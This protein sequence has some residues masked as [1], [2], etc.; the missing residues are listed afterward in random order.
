MKVTDLIAVLT[1]RAAEVEGW[2]FDVREYLDADGDGCIQLCVEYSIDL[3]VT[4]EMWTA[5][6]DLPIP[7]DDSGV[8]STETG[9]IV[10]YVT[11][12]VLEG[13]IA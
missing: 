3:E 4:D 9:N 12:N 11:W 5:F 1:A 6:G 7:Q 2:N 13:E 10:Q 8:D